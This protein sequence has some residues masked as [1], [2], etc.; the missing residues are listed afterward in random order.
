MKEER[1]GGLANSRKLSLLPLIAATFFMVSGGPYGSEDVVD[2][3]G[4][5]GALLIFLLVPLLWSLPTALMVSEL[6]S[7]LPE[8]GGFYQWVK[9]GMGPFWGFQEAWL[10]LAGSVFDMA[11]YPTLFV[12]YIAHFIPSLA[13]GRWPALLGLGMIFICTVWNICGTRAVGDGALVMAVVLLAPFVAL[14]ALALSAPGSGGRSP[15]V[16]GHADWLGAVLIAMWNLMGWDNP[17]TIAGEVRGP[18]RAYP[19][20]MAGAMALIVL[21]YIAPIGAIAHTGIDPNTWTTGGWVDLGRHF[22]GEGLAAALAIGGVIGAIGSFNAL[23]LSLSRLPLVMTEDGYLP[24]VFA[25]RHPRT[26]MPWVAIIACAIGWA[27]AFRLGFVALAVMDVLLTGLSVLLEFCALVALRIREPNLYRPY[28][29]PGGLT[30]AIAIAIGPAAL[31]ALAFVRNGTE[32][33]RHFD[34]LSLCLLLIALGPVIYWL[35]RAY[36]RRAGAQAWAAR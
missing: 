20:T 29:V 30:G 28:R 23:M 26:G 14:I 24:R 22:G 31:I 21:T 12:Y 35:S 15:V 18:Q 4:Y 11:L 7:A 1:R 10:S 5:A 25:R 19:R 17:S 2:K 6:S 13:T 8:E 33:T 9:R 16:L 34:A 32:H 27:A 3:A 36:Q